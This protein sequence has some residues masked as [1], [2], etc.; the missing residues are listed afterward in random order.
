MQNKTVMRYVTLI[1]LEK[2]ASL[3]IENVYED[4]K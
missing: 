4:I 1:R 2:Y 3:I